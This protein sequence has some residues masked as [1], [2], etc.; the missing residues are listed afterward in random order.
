MKEYGK[1]W[2]KLCDVKS[3]ISQIC[4]GQYCDYYNNCFIVKFKLES[5]GTISTEN[6]GKV[7]YVGNK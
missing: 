7:D 3:H 1:F 4:D 6:I 2:K 5:D